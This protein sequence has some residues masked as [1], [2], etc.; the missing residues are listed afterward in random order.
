MKPSSLND[1]VIPSPTDAPATTTPP[2]IRERAVE[3]ALSHGGSVTDVT[4]F[5][6]EEAERELTAQPAAGSPEDSLPADQTPRDTNIGH[7]VPNAPSA[8][9]DAE[10]RSLNEQLVDK[11][12]ARAARDHLVQ[13]T[14][15]AANNDK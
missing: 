3:I 1:G 6:R 4:A 9:E 7:Q 10:G 14:K 12:L 15:A 8:D 2:D 5:D 11:G 13:A